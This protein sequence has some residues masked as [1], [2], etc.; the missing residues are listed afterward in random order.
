[1]PA[2]D[3]ARVADLYDLYATWEGDIPFFREQAKERHNVLEL[4]SGTGRLSVPL[5]EAGVQLTCLD[6]SPAMLSILRR[7][8]REKGL[9][10]QI[11]EADVTSFDM[12]GRF[13][14]IV[15]PFHSFSE[16][17]EPES[18]RRALVTIRKHLSADGRFVCTLQSPSPRLLMADG[19]VHVRGR[20]RLPRG[21]GTLILSTVEIY[22]DR[23][24]LV[25]G[26][27]FYEILDSEG[28]LREKR[29]MDVAFYVHTNASMERLLGEAGYR[30]LGLFGDYNGAEFQAD[31]SPFMIW[32]TT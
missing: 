3:Y 20:F 6:S 31:R 18:Q 25:R 5:L 12:P 21:E 13:D 4:M 22:D 10:A 1:M 15:I 17:L 9:A 14:L 16:I 7:K 29:Q 27:Q 2:M 23:A 8:L 11:V 26:T 24:H 32:V 30:V 19:M 28:A